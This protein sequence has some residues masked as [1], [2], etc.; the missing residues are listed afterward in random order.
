MVHCFTCNVCIERFDHHCPW[1]GSC[2]G[3]RNYRYFFI[4]VLSI[5][6]LEGLMIAQLIIFFAGRK[7]QSSGGTAFL[8][9][10]IILMVYASV[11]TLF[12]YYLLICHLYLMWTN[13]TTYE[14]LKGH[15]D[16]RAGDPFKKSCFWNCVHWLCFGTK[17]PRFSNP[18]EPIFTR[19]PIHLTPKATPTTMVTTPTSFGIY[20]VPMSSAHQMLSPRKIQTLKY[21]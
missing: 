15:W 9:M 3:K 13:T 4:F 6:I 7:W 10:N 12:V 17:R 16:T 8:V 1:L 14:F 21:L 18:C 11:F 2:V 20:D 5:A 19:P